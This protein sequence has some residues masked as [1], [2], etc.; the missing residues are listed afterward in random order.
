MTKEDILLTGGAGYI[1]RNINK[2]FKNKYKNFNILIFDKKLNNDLCNYDLIDEFFKNNNIK[3]VIHLASYKCITESI[4]YPLEYYENNI[5]S[6]INLINVME[7]NNCYNLIFSSSAS[8]YGKI[9]SPIKEN[10]IINLNNLN[11]Y[12]KTKHIIEN[13][14]IDLYNSNNKWNIII[15]RYFNPVA[16]YHNDILNND[17]FSNIIDAYKNDDMFYIYGNK[18]NTL[19]GTCIRDFIHMD[20]LV[21]AHIKSILYIYNRKK[22]KLKIY[23]IG[24]NK[25]YSIKEI[26][27]TF[28]YLLY[29]NKKQRIK[30]KY[31]DNRI[32]DIEVSYACNKLAKEELNWYPKKDLL[33]MIMDSLIS[34][35][36][37]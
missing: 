1:G 19:D 7:N 30:F 9:K 37:I 10:S 15:L 11:P 18:Y 4:L 32:N 2:Y 5:L 23:N 26:I 20:D 28:N 13:L 14:L 35:N 31:T 22:I 25:G 21:E 17:L 36:Y 8:I 6:T 12:G 29:I 27:N 16:G 34:K 33:N 3:Y 24:T